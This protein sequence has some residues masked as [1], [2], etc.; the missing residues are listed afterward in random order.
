MQKNVIFTLM[1]VYSR[2]NGA[3]DDSGRA[4]ILSKNLYKP[5]TPVMYQEN[6]KSFF[7]VAI[8]SVLVPEDSDVYLSL[9]FLSGQDVHIYF[10][11]DSPENETTAAEPPSCVH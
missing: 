11:Q 10:P 5:G 8:F 4:L 9:K 6:G 7:G 3:L 1:R 2:K